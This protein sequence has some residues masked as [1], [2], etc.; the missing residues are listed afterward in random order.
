M[1][2]ATIPTT[3]TPAIAP[4]TISPMFDCSGVSELA[5]V[6]VLRGF[7]VAKDAIVLAIGELVAI[8]A[9]PNV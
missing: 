3:A 1:M 7:G 5:E 2:I 6:E 9:G 8:G 4:P